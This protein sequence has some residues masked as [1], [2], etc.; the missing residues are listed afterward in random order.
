MKQSGPPRLLTASTVSASLAISAR[1]HRP[2]THHYV[3]RLLAIDQPL[4]IDG[5]PSYAEVDQAAAGHVRAEARLIGTYET[6][7]SA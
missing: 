3:F 2:G 1:L 6:P 4:K 5:K 7:P